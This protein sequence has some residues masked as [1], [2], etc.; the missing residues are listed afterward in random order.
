M[1]RVLVGHLLED[2]F[3][4]CL[5]VSLHQA[6]S[7]AH[8]ALDDKFDALLDSALFHAGLGLSV[9][10]KGF[11]AVAYPVVEERSEVPLKESRDPAEI[12]LFSPVDVSENELG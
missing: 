11:V 3:C 10:S 2:L 9:L 4:E 8:G 7:A 12:A 1:L 5:A 6:Q